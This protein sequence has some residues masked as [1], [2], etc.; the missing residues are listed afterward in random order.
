MLPLQ[1]LTAV[2]DNRTRPWTTC[3]L[4]FA[5]PQDLNV[6]V[7][8]DFLRDAF[9]PLKRLTDFAKHVCFWRPFSVA[10]TRDDSICNKFTFHHAIIF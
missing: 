5:A 10:M 8:C 6:V 1:F 2:D 3:S 4:T 7:K 9:F